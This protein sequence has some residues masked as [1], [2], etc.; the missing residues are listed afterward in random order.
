MKRRMFLG[1]MAV[2][3]AAAVAGCGAGGNDI[4][5]DEAQR[6]ALE[7]AGTTEDEVTRLRVSQD[8]DDGRKVYEIQ[9]SLDVTDYEYEIQASDGTILSSD[10]EETG[11]AQ[12]NT[13]TDDGAQ[14]GQETQNTQNT[15]QVALSEADARALALERVPGAGEQDVRMELDYDDGQYKYEGDI[16]YNNIEYDFE[17][18]ANTGTFLEW[19]EERR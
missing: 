7:D 13:Q 17:I 11:T 12:G 18:D 9:F 3:A 16:I 19:S 10:R 14:N 4:G 2:L 6:I 8:S 15:Q 5:S 1:C